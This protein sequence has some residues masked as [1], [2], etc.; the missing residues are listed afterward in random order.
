[1]AIAVAV[2]ALN[3]A[4]YAQFSVTVSAPS[5]SMTVPTGSFNVTATVSNAPAPI[6]KIVFYKN[7]V[8][9]QT[10]T[11]SSTTQTI[12]ENV[13]QDTYTYRARA[14]A[15]NGD[16][17]DSSDF[18]L[19][20]RVPS[21]KMFRMGTSINGVSTHG[22]DRNFDHTT[23][24]QNALNYIGNTVGGGTLYFP[25]SGGPGG[26]ISFYNISSTITV[27][28]NVTIQSESSEE[29]IYSG[30][31]R[32]YWI[33]Q[34][35]NPGGC[36]NALPTTAQAMF[37]VE[38]TKARVRFK[39]LWIVSRVLGNDCPDN[40]AWD[41]IRD[42][43]TTGILLDAQSSGSVSDVIIENVSI[44]GFTY[45]IKA[46]GN[47]VSDIKMRGVRPSTNHRQ[48]YINATYAYDWDVQNFNLGG[49][50]TNQGAIEIINAGAPSGYTGE[51][52]KIKFLQLNC[53]G[54]FGRTSAFCARIEKHGGLYFKGLHTEGTA[55][56]I[57]VEDIGSAVNTEPII[58]EYSGV[59]GE[60]NDDS[61]KIYLVG[62]GLAAAPDIVTAQQTNHPDK[63]RF[64]FIG[65]GVNSTLVDCGDI[66][67]DRTDTN[68]NENPVDPN[69]P[70]GWD[71]WR[72][73]FTH[74]E[75]N[76]ESF[77]AKLSTNVYY[78]KP[79][80]VCP[81]G[82][83]GLPNINDV[84]GEHFNTGVI[85]TDEE[86]PYTTTNKFSTSSCL[87][88]SSAADCAATLQTLLN[89]T[90][91]S[92]T[93][94]IVGPVTVDREIKIP[95]GKQLVGGKNSS[96]QDGELILSLSSNPSTPV[97][98]LQI[99]MNYYIPSSCTPTP[100]K[101]QTCPAL[102]LRVS[103]ITVC[104]LKLS[105][106]QRNTSG[107]AIVGLPFNYITGV[108]SDIHFSDLTVTGFGKGLDVRRY[109]PSM[110]HQ[111]VDGVSWKN[112]K[113]VDNLT[114]ASVLP[115]NISNWNIIGLSMESNS[116]GAVGWFH[117]NTG[118]LFQNVACKGTSSNVME[119]CF[120]LEMAGIYLTGLKKSDYVKNDVTF[121]DTW[122]MFDKQ[123]AA[124]IFSN[125]VLRNNDFTGS[126]VIE[127][128][129]PVGGVNFRGK[130]VVTSMNN[131]YK[132]F[133]VLSGTA[134]K[135][136]FSRVTYCADTFTS[137][138]F[139][140]L[141]PSTDNLYV[142]VQTPALI[143]CGNGSSAPRPKPWE[144][145]INLADPTETV[146]GPDTPLVGNF[147]DN[148][149]EDIVVYRRTSNSKF[150]I[151]KADGSAR[152]TVGWGLPGDTPLIGRFIPG[153][154]SQVV[155]WRENP[156]YNSA[157]WV[158]DPNTTLYYAW[159]FGL[160]GDKPFIANLIDESSVVTG[161]M[162]EYAIYRPNNGATPTP[163]GEIWIENPR[164]LQS[165]NFTVAPNNPTEI[166][167]GDFLGLGYNQVAQYNNGTWNIVNPRNLKRYTASLG[168]QTGDVPIAGKFLSGTCTQIGIWRES[169]EQFIVK[170]PAATPDDPN[171]PYVSGCGSRTQS[172][173][174]GSDNDSPTGSNYETIGITDCNSAG[175]CPNDIPLK[176]N[177]PNSTVYRPVA[178]RPTNGVYPYGKA[179]G[180]WW[181]HDPF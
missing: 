132:T 84:G 22:P 76:R 59:V 25:C 108:S 23:Q 112:I 58:F 128:G 142:G 178:Y 37:K 30:R 110:T 126:G 130:V 134:N 174:W 57:I 166:Q 73:Q 54:D 51:N 85:P 116:S 107:I 163:Q 145:V 53:N 125:T 93:V 129:V 2:F 137:G 77:F 99:N 122:W 33:N 143:Q 62:N 26:D 165:V 140:G 171:D 20:V 119:H 138:T 179:K 86:L 131:K 124:P 98:L 13:G 35:P 19:T 69:D 162:D 155:V 16:Q 65:A 151:S 56:S 48:L 144:G 170:D 180:Q 15:S 97:D 152:Q 82:V 159:S 127:N 94:Q 41:K 90:T 92:G 28:S 147:Y 141:Q 17:V 64:E 173:Y 139:T 34:F 7:D 146:S 133:T 105:T 150:I 104:N 66:H 72:M 32:F 55:K 36:A 111:M 75:R 14:Y 177:T 9:Y 27:P 121:W 160:A 181:I 95:S 88:T 40:G 135:G 78:P 29:G 87:P 153:S 79:H 5:N 10:I 43:L 24:I 1:M 172:M 38:G 42:Q 45:G 18:K 81:S 4:A 167:V 44:T 11:G 70:V 136:E 91:D 68:Y 103:G 156:P 164:S 96:G 67:G 71:D 154:R 157:I 8:P 31:C 120:K 60:I 50:I 169:T 21:N 113:F 101:G 80:T 149:L 100:P 118:A 176:I 12:T 89:S 3:T 117:S 46:V 52:K 114:S 74:G 6:S 115:S 83:S 175:K 39:D 63:A 102:P 49:M 47:S 161:N 61:A 123:Y 109:D 168:G 106:N 158:Y 148:T